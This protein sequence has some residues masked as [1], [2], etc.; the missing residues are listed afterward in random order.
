L[1]QAATSRGPESK[2]KALIFRCQLRELNPD[3]RFTNLLLPSWHRHEPISYL[4]HLCDTFNYVGRSSRRRT[5][6]SV[7]EIHLLSAV[8]RRNS[9][10]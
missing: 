8:K 4:L 7:S 1:R 9:H 5:R 10:P 2:A 3:Q 6:G